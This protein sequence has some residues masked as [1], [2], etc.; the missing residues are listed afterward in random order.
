MKTVKSL[1]LLVVLVAMLPN[2]ALHAQMIALIDYMKVP[3]GGDAEYL[4][5]EQE[6][7][8]SMHQEWV[9]QGKMTGWYLWSIPYPGGTNP[10]I[11]CA[12]PR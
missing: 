1:L 12:R 6:I 8:K 9:N 10:T 11:G 3:E 4:K 5:V 7:W 2:T